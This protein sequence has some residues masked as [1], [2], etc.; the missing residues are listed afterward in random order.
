MQEEKNRFCSFQLA[1][2]FVSTRSR[3]AT[4]AA[5]AVEKRKREIV[6]WLFA[7]PKN[8]LATSWVVVKEREEREHFVT[9]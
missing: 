5:T 7:L 9:T 8:P 6:K 1:L 3:F 2:F 4:N